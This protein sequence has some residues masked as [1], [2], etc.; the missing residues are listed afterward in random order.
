[1]NNH[2]VEGGSGDVD[3][4]VMTH[5]PRINLVTEG[6]CIAEDHVSHKGVEED[7]KC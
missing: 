5:T 4:A 1:M 6:S 7:P 2:R 3:C